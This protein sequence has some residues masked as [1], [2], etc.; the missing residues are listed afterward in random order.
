MS[1]VNIALLQMSPLKHN[2]EGNKLIADKYCREA[3][4]AGADI[5]VFPELF[6]IGYVSSKD[7]P[8]P[9][10]VWHN[11]AFNGQKPDYDMVQRYVN[12]AI[13]DTHEYVIHFKN[14]ARELGVAIAVT[15]LSK[16][17]KYPRNTVNLFDMTGKSILKYSKI[18]LFEPLLIDAMCEPGDEYKVAVIKTRNATFNIGA[19][20]CADR[21]FP[22][23]SRIM[24]KKGAELVIIPNACPLKGAYN[25]IVHNLVRVRAFEN[26]IPMVICNYPAPEWDGYS[27]G[28]NPDGTVIAEAGQEQEIL[29]ISYDIDTIREFRKHTNQGNAF[30]KEKYY[31]LITDSK[32]DEPFKDRKNALG[33]IR[34]S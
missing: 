2:I 13:E 7:L 18:H 1:K 23:P 32:V 12:L 33:I 11:T 8:N 14:L 22:E 3:A 28:F 10:E 4:K 19:L 17:K 9:F 27:A 20:I 34:R 29:E 31:K 21:D 25:E 26:A 30:R 16:G 24:M 6:S 5:I 15:Y